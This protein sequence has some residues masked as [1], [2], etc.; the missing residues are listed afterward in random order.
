MPFG[1]LIRE[2]LTNARA[3]GRFE[4]LDLHR[5]VLTFYLLHERS[6]ANKS[7][8]KSYLALLPKS[9]STF[10]VNFAE[11]DIKEYGQGEALFDRYQ[12]ELSERDQYRAFGEVLNSIPTEFPKATFSALEI[13]WAR[14]VVASRAMADPASPAPTTPTNPV[15]VNLNSEGKPLVLLPLIDMVNHHAQAN[16]ELHFEAGSYKL[17]SVQD[18]EAGQQL[19]MSYA[20]VMPQEMSPEESLASFGLV[21]D[22]LSYLPPVF[23]STRIYENRTL[24]EAFSHLQSAWDTEVHNFTCVGK[25]LFQGVYG[26][27]YIPDLLVV[28]ESLYM[29]TPSQFEQYHNSSSRQVPLAVVLAAKQRLEDQMWDAF[30]RQFKTTMPEDQALLTNLSSDLTVNALN[31]VR[32][33]SFSKN[34]LAMQ[35]DAVLAGFMHWLESRIQLHF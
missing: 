20:S 35:M 29:M 16:V 14:L 18:I 27:P 5:L 4:S 26:A 9:F 6:Q 25:R 11:S 22:G 3:E 2:T 31:L 15:G 19:V 13:E 8:W 33:R 34:V 32:A 28:C 23:Y 12:Q 7:F 10:L 1:K 30:K 17:V 24:P 21:L